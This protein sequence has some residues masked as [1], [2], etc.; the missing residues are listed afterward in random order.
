[1][2]VYLIENTVCGK[3]YNGST[4]KKFRARAINYKS[5]H[6]KFRKEKKLSKQALSQKRF[7]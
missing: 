3:Q 6:R 7:H 1:M 5:T 2:V 4:M